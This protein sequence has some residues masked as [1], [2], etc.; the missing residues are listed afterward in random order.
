MN[1]AW[2]ISTIILVCMAILAILGFKLFFKV[3]S[4]PKPSKGEVTIVEIGADLCLPCKLLSPIMEEITLELK[5][6]VTVH[7]ITLG[8]TSG[9]IK[10]F[11]DVS[12]I[13]TIIIFDN[14]A[15]EITRRVFHEDDV[16]EAK[17]WIRFI[18]SMEGVQW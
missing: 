17:E 18:V 1:N 4:F 9:S 2:K 14:N 8:N 11:Y 10:S 3:T 15:E 6:N 7:K 5:D 16:E 13:P 12:V